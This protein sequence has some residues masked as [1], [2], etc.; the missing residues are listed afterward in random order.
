MNISQN[1]AN[2][3]NN[4]EV[5]S[6]SDIPFATNLTYGSSSS[7]TIYNDLANPVYY[8]IN[9]GGTGN[10]GFYNLG[11]QAV[12][13]HNAMLPNGKFMLSLHWPY[14]LD[15]PSGNNYGYRVGSA[16]LKVTYTVCD[17]PVVADNIT[18]VSCTSTNDGSIDLILSGGTG[19]FAFNWSNGA[20]TE[21]I[22][23]LA[24]GI[25]KCTIT[26]GQGAQCD[27]VK[28]YTVHDPNRP[29]EFVPNSLLVTTS[30]QKTQI[31]TWL[32]TTMAGDL[33]YRGSVDGFTASAFHTK[34]DNQGA[35]LFIARNATTNE[36]FGGYNP[37]SW[38]SSGGYQ[39]APG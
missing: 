4:I 16:T 38:A 14:T 27:I 12:T 24:R 32:G 17:Q 2:G 21:D 11:S 18:N 29:F 25:Y 19:P 30:S 6:V 33:L 23:N 15:P 3:N 10:Y 7:S 8:T 36:I 37:V 20:T 26:T 13:D 1:T 5:T 34:C 9:A 31:Q 22:S 35:T 39:P 28:E